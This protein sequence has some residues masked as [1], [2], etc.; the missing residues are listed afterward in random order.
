MSRYC[1]AQ[2]RCAQDALNKRLGI[3]RKEL[4]KAIGEYDAR[5]QALEDD[6]TTAKV[7]VYVCACVCACACVCV[8][9]EDC[10][11]VKCC[12]FVVF[13]RRAA[14][15]CVSV[16]L[17]AVWVCA[18]ARSCVCVCVCVIAHRRFTT[19]VTLA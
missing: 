6:I 15:A 7:C 2:C 3:L 16:S 4:D 17:H 9:D 1:D 8:C 19:P 18:S 11:A 10:V 14:A 5:L 13:G 12:S